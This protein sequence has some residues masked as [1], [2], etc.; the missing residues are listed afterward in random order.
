MRVLRVIARMNMGGPA[1]HVSILSGRLDPARYET[2]LV[3]GEVPPGEASAT[4]L[5][6][7]HGATV[8][9]LSSLGPRP[10]PWSDLLTLVELARLVR[11]VRPDL[12]HTHTA[13]AGF[14]GRAAA[15]AI[16][17]RPRIVHTYHGH[18]LEGYFGPVRNAVY[19]GLER[20][21][22]R[23]SD[24]L[25]GVSRRTVADLVRLRIAPAERFR[26]IP[27]GLDLEPFLELPPGAG[28][29]LREEAGAG[30]DDV[31]VG[32]VGRLVAIKRLDVALRAVA[33]ARAAGTPVRLAV[34]GDGELR[35]ALERQA[36][37]LGIAGAVAFLGY[38]ADMPEV[39][40][41]CDVALLTSD[42]EG[43]PVWLVEAAAAGRPAVA[44]DV[45]GVRDVVADG[46]GLLAPAEAAQELGAA[47]RRLAADPEERRAMGERARQH[48]RRTFSI[49][50]LLRDVDALYR[51]LVPE[52]S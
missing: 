37:E 25:V 43:T 30:P 38:R 40:A 1:H 26:V 31:L 14:V 33:A 34:V 20:L 7:R 42:N 24:R 48:V 49:D 36:A 10:R 5:A 22:G 41:A 32:Y 15:L 17:P 18:V 13:K 29:R 35:P 6:Q 44:T 46:C 12:V 4:A 11:R 28:G 39:A 19:R 27:L 16:R 51:E 23:V 45:G 52:T 21:L 8:Q 50:R 9:V 47:L 3:S 2:V